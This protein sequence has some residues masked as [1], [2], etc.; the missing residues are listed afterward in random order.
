MAKPHTTVSTRKRNSRPIADETPATAVQSAA[1]VASAP[2][3]ETV[4]TGQPVYSSPWQ[5]LKHTINHG[6]AHWQFWLKFILLFAVLNLVLVHNFSSDISSLKSQLASFLG[7]NSAATGLGTYALL[8]SGNTSASGAAGAYQYLLL[9]I[10]SLAAIWALRQ[11]MSD[12]PPVR[13]RLRDSL[14]RGMSPFIPFVLV[15]VVL[16]LELI[17]VL[18][19]G[20]LYSIVASGGIIRSWLEQL[21]FLAIF[22]AGL[23]LTL[24]LLMRSVFALYIVTLSDMTPLRALRDAAQIVKRR[25][26]F[27][28]RRMVFLLIVLLL[29][30]MAV[31]LPVIFIVPG[32]TQWLFFLLSIA[33]LPF[34]HAYLYTMYRELLG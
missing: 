29:G 5:L 6:R 26:L 2:T 15:L 23:G 8:L 28:M 1:P 33:A 17:P 20:S 22:F 10:G 34:V 19:A 18:L 24:W 13:L 27:I 30:S 12:H 11:F 21:L 31:L 25:Q 7:S 9:I 14:Y 16:S 3:D 4:T 32:L